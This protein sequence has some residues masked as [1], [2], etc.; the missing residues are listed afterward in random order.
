[1]RSRYVQMEIEGASPVGLVVRMYDGA[2]GSIRR[3]VCSSRDGRSTCAV[4]AISLA[5][6][7]RVACDSRIL[8]GAVKTREIRH[9]GVAIKSISKP[10]AVLPVIRM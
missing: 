3:A 10:D 6:S 5:R 1:M 8:A 4:F 7:D 2:L 9:P